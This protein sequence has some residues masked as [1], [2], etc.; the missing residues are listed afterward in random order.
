MLLFAVLGLALSVLY[1]RL[2][3]AR[4]T[5]Q[6]DVYVTTTGT[7][8][9]SELTSGSN[10]AEAQAENFALI[11]TRQRV[12]EPVVQGLRLT[13]TPDELGRSIS[14]TVPASTSVILIQVEDTSPRRAADIANA[15]SESLTA[16][17]TDLLPARSGEPAIRLQVVQPAVVPQVPSSPNIVASTTLGLGCGLLAGLALATLLDSRRRRKRAYSAAVAA[18][19]HDEPVPATADPEWAGQQT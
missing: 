14:A 12:L 10:Y 16:T 11:A 1:V 8:N 13:T 15:V 18:A 9:V 3:P 7:R 6:T 19:R 4:Y 17:A 5:A 2:V